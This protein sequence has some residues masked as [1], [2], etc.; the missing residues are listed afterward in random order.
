MNV[1]NLGRFR[2]SFGLVRAPCKTVVEEFCNWQQAILKPYGF[3]LRREPMEGTLAGV[4]EALIPRT[5]PITTRYLFWP[6]GSWTLYFDNSIGGTDA[7][8]PKVLSARMQV[9]AIRAVA[10]IEQIEP[11]GRVKKYG[12]TMFEYYIA[13]V[14]RRAVFAADDGGKWKFHQSG[15]PFAFEE[16]DCYSARPI[17]ARFTPPMLFRYLRQLSVPLEDEASAPA[18]E[19]GSGFL[20]KKHGKMPQPFRE[21]YE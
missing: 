6:L 8:P 14:P 21:V 11:N 18:E 9:D 5:A 20:V 12:A 15:E 1:E 13:G 17:K 7:S 4:L 3:E 16:H 2:D 10:A 19:H